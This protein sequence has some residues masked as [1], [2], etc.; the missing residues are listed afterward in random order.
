MAS[1][2]MKIKRIILPMITVV[3]LVSQLTGCALFNREDTEKI[4]EENE[5]VEL[6]IPDKADTEENLEYTGS[7]KPYEVE[8]DSEA[9]IEEEDTDI[10]LLEEPMT[11]GELESLFEMTYA[12]VNHILV[13]IQ[14][15]TNEEEIIAEEINNIP[16][17]LRDNFP[18]KVLP[19][20]YADQY[21]A[22]R[23][24]AHPTQAST[25]SAPQSQPQSQPSQSAPSKPSNSQPSSSTSKPSTSNTGTQSKPSGNPN[26][27]N[28]S[29]D[30]VTNLDK[31]PIK[32]SD[33]TEGITQEQIDN[34]YNGEG[35]LYG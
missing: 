1:K 24:E 10:G 29:S 16:Y 26:T 34:A 5:Q 25:P 9:E 18:S 8:V 33:P 28:D 15:W 14:G 23:L 19:D 3:L 17:Y 30:G 6:V 27:V 12:E 20:D 32:W 11:T 35:T 2:Y 31:N 21:R 22:W 7:E 4:L 13:K